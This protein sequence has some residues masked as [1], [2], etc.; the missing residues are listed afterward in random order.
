[1]RALMLVKPEMSLK[2]SVAS[3]SLARVVLETAGGAELLRGPHGASTDVEA[4][5]LLVASQPRLGEH[6]LDDGHALVGAERLHQVARE[7]RRAH[8][9]LVAPVSRAVSIT[10][11]DVARSI[12]LRSASTSSNPVMRG[13]S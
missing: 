5:R 12:S 1:M 2:S 7:A 8:L 13:M 10:M 11:R 4:R 3:T 9:R 6:P